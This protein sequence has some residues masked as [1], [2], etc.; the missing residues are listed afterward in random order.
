M[1]PRHTEVWDALTVPLPENVG[2]P[3]TFRKGGHG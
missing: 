1:S 3:E 2:E